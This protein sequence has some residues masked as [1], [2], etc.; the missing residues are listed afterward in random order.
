[1][2]LARVIDKSFR[3]G[4]DSEKLPVK[5]ASVRNL[6]VIAAYELCDALGDDAVERTEAHRAA[7]YVLEKALGIT[8]AITVL[9]VTYEQCELYLEYENPVPED[10][11]RILGVPADSL[12][13]NNRRLYGQRY[14]DNLSQEGARRTAGVVTNRNTATPRPRANREYL[15]RLREAKLFIMGAGSLIGSQL[16]QL[17]VDGVVDTLLGRRDMRRILVVNHV[18]MDETR[19][20]TLRDHIRLIETVAT[21]N[22]SA[23]VLD[24][25]ASG[26]RRVRISDLFTDIIVPRT[27]ARELEAE[28]H[29]CQFSPT[30]GALDGPEFVE[31]KGLTAERTIKILCNKYIAFLREHPEIQQQL[32][33]TLRE[34]EVLS[35][36]DQPPTLYANRSEAGRY[37]GA[38]FATDED[39]RYLVEQGI[40]R[41]NIHEID[42]IGENSKLVKSEGAPTFEFFPGLV[43]EALV[44]IIRIALERGAIQTEFI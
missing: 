15:T 7:I 25:R 42:S 28:M 20:M 43:P 2:N 39:V 31:L 27:V 9:P 18:K 37:R 36:L 19:D 16:A 8:S 14:I 17:A 12:R 24:E 35:Y 32:G 6:N 3:L 38:L 4:T 29:A 22:A 40:Q 34:L 1:M 11:A 44:G 13:Q 41:R 26:T 5:G 21:E 33:V 23:A 10:L 30:K